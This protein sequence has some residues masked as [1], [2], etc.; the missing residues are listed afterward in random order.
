MGSENLH[1]SERK[2]S[3]LK[4]GAVAALAGLSSLGLSQSVLS[5][6]ASASE[7]PAEQFFL[8]ELARLES[9]SNS[10]KPSDKAEVQ[11]YRWAPSRVSAINPNIMGG[12]DG[13]IM[14]KDHS[15][16]ITFYYTF[17]RTPDSFYNYRNF[18]IS[19]YTGSPLGHAV[20]L[21]PPNF[22]DISV[23]NFSMLQHNKGK[24]LSFSQIGGSP[25]V[26]NNEN[27]FVHYGK[28]LPTV[29]SKESF[30]LKQETQI[31]DL[32]NTAIEVMKE[33]ENGYVYRESI[34]HKLVKGKLYPPNDAPKNKI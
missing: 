27:I 20:A 15:T 4:R 33:S 21:N 2:S 19:L 5:Q 28:A 30:S 22:N 3:K 14:S 16:L 31:N 29:S 7:P 25:I 9:V 32:V 6:E 12:F 34:F 10:I 23:Y 18:S 8:H 13:N 24:N 1:Y 11:M 17:T 26:I